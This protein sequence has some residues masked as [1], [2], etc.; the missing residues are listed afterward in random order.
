[1][2]A[3]TGG[4][5]VLTGMLLLMSG[6]PPLFTTV[7]IQ[8]GHWAFEVDAFGTPVSIVLLED[9]STSGLPGGPPMGYVEFLGT[10]TWTQMGETFTMNQD[11]PGAGSFVYTGT[12]ITSTYMEGTTTS[13][14]S[15]GSNWTATFVGS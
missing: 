13:G 15:A 4:L 11:V 6:C 7:L 3:K 2:H 9:G 1:M 8:P 14:G 5:L 12:V 10:L